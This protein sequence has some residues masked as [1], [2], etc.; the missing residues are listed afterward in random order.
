MIKNEFRQLTM[1]SDSYKIRVNLKVALIGIRGLERPTSDAIVKV[2]LTGQKAN[3]ESK[4]P[5][6]E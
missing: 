4:K 6:W 1:S 5:Y 2:Y 3:Q